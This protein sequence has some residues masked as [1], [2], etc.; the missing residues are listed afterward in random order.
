M[1]DNQIV[2]SDPAV[3]T[4]AE[5]TQVSSVVTTIVQLIKDKHL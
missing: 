2:T 4:E 1:N 5:K 3:L